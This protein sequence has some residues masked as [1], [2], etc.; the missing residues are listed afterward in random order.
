MAQ[1]AIARRQ[2]IPRRD[3]PSFPASGR[4]HRRTS[5]CTGPTGNNS[6]P[7]PPRGG[8]RQE[9]EQPLCQ[10]PHPARRCV[11]FRR[12]FHTHS[13]RGC[14]SVQGPGRPRR[15]RR[16]PTPRYSPGRRCRCGSGRRRRRPPHRSTRVPRRAWGRGKHVGI[17]D[18]QPV[19]RRSSANHD[20]AARDGEVEERLDVLFRGH[21]P[22][23]EQ[24]RAGKSASAGCGATFGLKWS[25][26][27]PRGQM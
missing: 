22:D 8:S 11:P 20:L 18:F 7:S 4:G 3:R 23:V 16:R 13:G 9:R 12:A 17:G 6:P 27:T 1:L 10:G 24:D 25:R 14:R 26:S 21:P 15:G 5:S 2:T 19:E